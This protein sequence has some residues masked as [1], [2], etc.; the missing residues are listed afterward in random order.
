M[1]YVHAC[2]KRTYACHEHVWTTHTALTSMAHEQISFLCW[3]A[4]ASFFSI[5]PEKVIFFYFIIMLLFARVERTLSRK[6]KL[7]FVEC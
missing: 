5:G 7:K 1:K 4:L 6:K 3:Y 2:S